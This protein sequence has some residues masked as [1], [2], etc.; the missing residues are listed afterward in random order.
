MP[1]DQSINQSINTRA[2]ADSETK[3]ATAPDSILPTD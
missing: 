3:P 1:T 2:P